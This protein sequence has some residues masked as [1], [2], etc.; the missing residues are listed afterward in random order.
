MNCILI[1]EAKTAVSIPIIASIN[2]I[3]N[4]EWIYFTKKIE[5]AGADALELNISI[6]PS[7][8]KKS[9]QEIEDT[10]FN[11]IETVRKEIKTPLIIKM[12]SY[13]TNL[14]EMIQKVSK[15][16]INGLVLFN[17]YY[18]PDIDITTK[19]ITASNIFSSSDD[20]TL[21]LRWVAISSGKTGCSLAA[22]TGIHDGEGVIKMVLAGVDAVDVVSTIYKNGASQIKEMND[23]LIKYLKDQ[24]IESISL[25][26][27]LANQINIDNPALFERVQF[28]KYFSDNED[29]I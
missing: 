14:G 27:G 21:P 26:K 2:C 6:L 19:Q 15:S 8:M 18:S 9:S 29:I 28:M 16:G 5:A 7:D 22:S 4:Y 1:K 13:F 23:T 3:S 11:I 12:S 17:R 25:I 10:Y 24:D 20:I